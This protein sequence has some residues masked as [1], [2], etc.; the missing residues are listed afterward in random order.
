MDLIWHNHV[1]LKVSVFSSRLLRDRLP[2]KT[3]LATCG[4]ISD[5]ARLCIAG[6]GHVED[7]QHL[8]ITCT[9]FASLWPLVRAWIRF[10]GV[11]TQVISDHF[12]QFTYYTCGLKAR[13][14]FL[15]Q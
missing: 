14:S 3:N 2:T 9:S 7:A 12:T 10:D 11:D 5:V 15:Q 6:C 1:P 8:F 4:V 13:C